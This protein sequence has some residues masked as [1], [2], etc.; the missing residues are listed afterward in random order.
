ML[1]AHALPQLPVKGTAE[2][3]KLRRFREV[4]S[5]QGVGTL[6]VDWGAWDST[7]MAARAGLAR[8]ERLGI[9]AIAPTEGLGA[10]G[11]L[12][13]SCHAGWSCS[14]VIACVI[15]WDRFARLGRRLQCG[16]LA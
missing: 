14:Q 8:M 1:H 9:G 12:L 16:A 2:P 13:S 7:G 15:L 3:E 5:A 6:S 11:R 10:L 4:T